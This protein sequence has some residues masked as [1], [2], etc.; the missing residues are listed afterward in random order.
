M[1]GNV[2]ARLD[3]ETQSAGVSIRIGFMASLPHPEGEQHRFRNRTQAG[4]FLASRLQQYADRSDVLVVALPRGGVPVG[5]EVAKALHV[6]LD[7]LIVRKLGTPGQEELA[8]GA[9]ASGGFQVVNQEIVR[10][11]GISESEIRSIEARELRE[12]ERREQIYRA[13]RV[14]HEIRG[15]TVILVDD[16]VA[17]GTTV[18]VAIA[19]LRAQGPS[20][21]VAAFPVAA[22]STCEE[23]RSE[24]DELV[25][26]LTP[27]SLYAIGFWYE[28]FD[29][30]SDDTVCDLLKRAEENIAPTTSLSRYQPPTEKV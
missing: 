22:P 5:Y 15:K 10:M 26:L 21:I 29:A 25:C 7:I 16:G 12:L 3:Q 24:V 17:T 23:L 11:L 19:A 9:I 27:Q 13:G 6:P 30:T 4:L 20:S 18:R 14:P 8:M 1:I 28:D 2:I